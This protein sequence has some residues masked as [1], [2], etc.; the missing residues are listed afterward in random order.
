ME[1]VRAPKIP[2]RITSLRFSFGF[3][4]GIHQLKGIAVVD[5]GQVDAGDGIF[6]TYIKSPVALIFV[7]ACSLSVHG[8]DHQTVRTFR[9]GD[10]TL[11]QQ[12]GT[13]VFLV[14]GIGKLLFRAVFVDDGD[15]KGFGA[16]AGFGAGGK[17]DTHHES[18]DCHQGDGCDDDFFVFH[19]VFLLK[20]KLLRHQDWCRSR[21]SATSTSL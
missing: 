7:P 3:A 6:F 14:G 18:N 15:C 11:I 16:V 9:T 19:V 4:N 5:R 20:T 13:Q 21:F 8:L 10:Q 17:V 12:N 2:K 1:K